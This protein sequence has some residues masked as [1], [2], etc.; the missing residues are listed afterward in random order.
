MLR[1]W[2]G[3]G[4]FFWGGWVGDRKVE[5]NEAVGMSYCELELGR[6]VGGWLRFD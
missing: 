5:E 3:G 6:W 4:L 2:L 1:A